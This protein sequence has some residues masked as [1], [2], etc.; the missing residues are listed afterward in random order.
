MLLLM[1]FS[2][3][4]V[5]NQGQVIKYCAL[6]EGRFYKSMSRDSLLNRVRLEFPDAELEDSFSIHWGEENLLR[7][8]GF[9]GYLKLCPKAKP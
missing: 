5:L 2:C 3:H 9:E 7:Q 6:G 8:V 1:R 4:P